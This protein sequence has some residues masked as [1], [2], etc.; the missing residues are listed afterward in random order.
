MCFRD[1]TVPD[2]QPNWLATPPPHC[3]SEKPWAYWWQPQWEASL[4]VPQEQSSPLLRGTQAISESCLKES[5][6]PKDPSTPVSS[7]PAI[8][9]RS[10]A[11]EGTVNPHYPRGVYILAG[12]APHCPGG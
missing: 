9:G 5:N 11:R 10:F 6:L 4:S 1:L 2:S 8:P 12:G 3:F 7:P